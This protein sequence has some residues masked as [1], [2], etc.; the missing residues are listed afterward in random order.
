MSLT[1]Q[2]RSEIE[3]IFRAIVQGAFD[4]LENL[5]LS[6]HAIN[7]FLAV[8]V[9]RR[10]RE[11]A[12]FI[13]HQRVERGLVTSFGMQIQKIVWVVGNNLRPSGVGGADFERVDRATRRHVLGQLKSGPETINSDIANQIA[14]NL[15]SAESRLRQ[16]GLPSQWAVVKMLAMIYGTARHRNSWVMS[17]GQRG[18][19]VDKVGRHFWEFASGDPAAYQEVFDI[20]FQVA[21]TSR[22]AKG[23][24]LPE[25]I[26][27]AVASL[28]AEIRLVYGKTTGDIDWDRLVDENM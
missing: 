25:A 11:L 20:A 1:S 3:G 24:T 18:F 4:R 17:L 5:T 16:G 7:P 8:L 6:K 13:V 28:T 9:A 23:R 10:P 19:D 27:D 26:Q 22:D 12:E 15:N 21:E 2:Q 14:R